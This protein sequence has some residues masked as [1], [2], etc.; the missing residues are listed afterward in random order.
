MR[1]MRDMTDV[2][3]ADCVL[4][5]TTLAFDIAGLELYLPLICGARIALVDPRD[6]HDPEALARTITASGA[7]MAQATP[8]TWRMLLEAGWKGAPGLKACVEVRRCRS[9]W[10]GGFD[11][12]SGNCGM[13][14]GR[15]RPPSGRAAPVDASSLPKATA[16]ESIGRPIANTR[17]YVLMVTIWSRL[18]WEWPEKSTSA[19]P[20]WR[21]DI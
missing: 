14:M 8:A 7:T 15:L 19:G 5:L 3:P 21:E 17:I 1:S 2:G 6:S 12:G 16:H 18:R 10:P 20:A 9:N 11:S 4:A 13:C